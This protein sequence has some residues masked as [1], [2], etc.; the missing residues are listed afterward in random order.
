VLKVII[1]LFNM[2]NCLTIGTRAHSKAF[3]S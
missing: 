1:Q 2:C 3:P